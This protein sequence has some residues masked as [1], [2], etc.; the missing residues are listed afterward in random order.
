MMC[1]RLVSGQDKSWNHRANRLKRTALLRLNNS[2]RRLIKNAV[3]LEP[4]AEVWE[5]KTFSGKAIFALRRGSLHCLLYSALTLIASATPLWA[6][7]LKVGVI[8]SPP[9]VIQN[10]AQYDGISVDVWRAMASDN[11][12]QFQLVP[13]PTPLAGID[14][15]E[16]GQLDL[17][18]GPI[19]ITPARL[20]RPGVDFTQP[21][22]FA[23]SGVLVHSQSQTLFS[24][25]KVFFGWAAVSSV[26]VLMS[27]L[28]A[29]GSMIW[30]AE[31]RQNSSQFPQAVLPGLANG[32]WFA[33]VTLTT[34]GYGDKAPVTRVGKGVT[35]VWMV[36]SLIAVSSITAGL[37]SAFTL[38]LSGA[39]DGG[40]QSAAALKG[41]RV[42]VVAGTSG[43]ELAERG[44]MRTISVQNLPEAVQELVERDV[45]AVIFDRPA[46]RYYLKSN[47]EL[48]VRLAGFNL[49]EETYGFV[50]KPNS[51]LR[52][53]LDVS[54]LKLQRRHAVDKIVD[55]Y[56]F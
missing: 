35:A 6:E 41:R 28:V 36:M 45:E 5:G 39:T 24:R 14:A 40:I 15:V 3:I 30:L 20:A 37:A 49:A 9:F 25:L 26:L 4:T 44:Q 17:L 2:F 1:I 47:P 32:M 42:A 51:P 52:T 19:S 29:V 12:L 33:L 23:K 27:V 50:L 16:R 53:T 18:V 11:N 55:T 13:Q 21:Y 10:G 48:A 38:F 46:I 8:G 54:V 34:V 43:E 22:F 7:P 56:L 31:R